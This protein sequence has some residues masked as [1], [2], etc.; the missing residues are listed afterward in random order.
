MQL[1][2][3]I[4]AQIQNKNIVVPATEIFLLPEKVLQFGTGVL[5][6]GLCDYFIDKANK[7]NIFNGRVVIVKSTSQGGTDA[8][9][10][11]D[12]L[13][14]H[15]VKGIENGTAVEETVINA[16]ISR[17]LSAQD[18]W[19]TILQCAASADMQVIISNT[20]EVGITYSEE[21]ITEQ[22]PASF[23]GKLLAWLHERYK[24]FNGSADAGIIIIPT[25]LLIDNAGKLKAILIKLAHYN[26]FDESFIN[27]LQTA[28][29][30]CS[31]LVDRIVPGKINVSEAESGYTD[32]LAI[33]SEVYRL[34]AIETNDKKVIGTLSFAQADSGVVLAADIYKY[35]ELKLRLLNGPHTL[36]CGLAVLSGFVTVKEAMLDGDFRNYITQLMQ[37]EIA[38]AITDEQISYKEAIAYTKE[39]IDRFSNPFLEHKWLSICLQYSSK[40]LMR[41]IPILQKHYAKSNT[42]PHLMAIGFAAYILFMKSHQNEK[43][44]F[45]GN[46]NNSIYT[47]NDDKAATL[48]Q[49]W[50]KKELRD[51]VQGIL[52][53]ETLWS[54]DLNQFPEFSE[55]VIKNI[56]DINNR[57]TKKLIQS[58][59]SKNLLQ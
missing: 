31:S 45:I 29:Y 55:A 6:R 18:E 20:T 53:D 23:P 3:N 15:F 37:Q 12:G 57:G 11:Q 44:E 58:Y 28:N 24:I 16:S 56:T 47:I 13:Y 26:A 22:A 52:A 41:N 40:M 4:I 25:E 54:M 39:V 50:Q 1:S 7:Q 14:T 17:V 2:K 10:L 32:E 9:A 49:H 27:W 43:G 35:R 48:H 30:F 8:F 46:I 21:K 51:I 36:S 5:L 38:V 19:K 59:T 33:M 42:V 34:W